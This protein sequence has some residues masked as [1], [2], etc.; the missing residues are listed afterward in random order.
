MG[1][2]HVAAPERSVGNV[3]DDH[4]HRH[5]VGIGVVDCHRGMLQ[6]DRA[7]GHDHH[8]L[9]FDL[10]VSVCHRDRRLFMA[11]G[12]QLRRL[13]ATVIDDRLM[14]RTE[15]RSW[16]RG[17]IFDAQRLD[18]IQHEVRSGPVGRVNIDARGRGT[19]LRCR[20]RRRWKWNPRLSGLRSLRFARN[21][22]RDKRS[23]ADSRAL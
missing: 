7:M 19:R 16:I 10:R 17:D 11:A 23:R 8:R 21:R 3:A 12:Q 2:F 13:V 6:S 1:P 18:G 9:A 14:Q 22:F 5:A 4:I 20:K 15:R